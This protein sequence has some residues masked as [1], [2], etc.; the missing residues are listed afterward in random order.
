M[1]IDI[2]WYNKNTI[3]ASRAFVNRDFHKLICII[4]IL[5]F[6]AYTENARAQKT[7]KSKKI[8]EQLLTNHIYKI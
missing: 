1:P 3:I 2:I 8:S 4:D 5:M 7:K 6:G